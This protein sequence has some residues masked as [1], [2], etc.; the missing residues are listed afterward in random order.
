M[1]VVSQTL[2]RVVQN[3]DRRFQSRDRKGGVCLRDTSL[4]C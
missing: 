2:T 1:P 4:S 3:H